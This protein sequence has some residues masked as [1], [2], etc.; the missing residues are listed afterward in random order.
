MNAITSFFGSKKDPNQISFDI[1][2]PLT[3]ALPEVK[4]ERD[5]DIDPDLNED[6]DEENESESSVY[7]E[8]S[9]SEDS[10][11]LKA[12]KPHAK[13]KPRA[14]RHADRSSPKLK[15]YLS[16]RATRG[17]SSYI[18]NEFV[19][20]PM[21]LSKIV[22]VK[23]YFVVHVEKISVVLIDLMLSLP[24]WPVQNIKLGS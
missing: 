11:A 22:K 21:N 9:V 14:G 15:S 19:T 10:S 12:P 7:D 20:I 16:S 8:P 5:E 6:I 23:N 4:A 3:I 2:P 17:V 1:P 24:T 18:E 13:S